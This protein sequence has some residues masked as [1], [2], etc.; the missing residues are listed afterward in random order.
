MIHTRSAVRE[1]KSP[2]CFLFIAILLTT[3]LPASGADTESPSAA[4][5]ALKNHLAIDEEKRP[6]LS[7]QSFAKEPLTRN[8]A[9]ATGQLLW[10]NRNRHQTD[11][12]PT[13]RGRCTPSR[14]AILRGRS[15]RRTAREAAA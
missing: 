14:H 3:A 1:T 4:V 8:D 12:G 5:K 10:Q 11:K 15:A 2:P 13:R 7:E 9:L 6:P